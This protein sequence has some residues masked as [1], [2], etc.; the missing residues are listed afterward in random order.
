VRP[1][2]EIDDPTWHDLFDRDDEIKRLRKQLTESRNTRMSWDVDQV[3]F[4]ETFAEIEA[5]P[6]RGIED[7]KAWAWSALD[8]TQK[9]LRAETARLQNE[10]QAVINMLESL[11][12]GRGAIDDAIYMIRTGRH[13]K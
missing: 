11:I 6:A 10:R 5:D 4:Y 8:S 12:P 13:A 9:E 1:T 3:E 2:D 7:A